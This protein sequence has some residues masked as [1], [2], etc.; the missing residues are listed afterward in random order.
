MAI[1]ASVHIKIRQGP[2]PSR[3]GAPSHSLPLEDRFPAAAAILGTDF[4]G[5]RPAL[6]V[7][8][9]DNVTVGQVVFRDR[10][11]TDVAFVAP[12][13]GRVT[14]IDYGPR[15]TLSALVVTRDTQS[16]DNR[17]DVRIDDKTDAAVRQTLLERGMWP[18][19]QTRPFGRIPAPDAVPEA[20]FVNAMQASPLAPNPEVVLEG[21]EAEFHYGV[22]L[23]TR[24]SSGQTY[25]CQAPGQAFCDPS[26]RISIA[27]FSGTLAAGLTGTH[28]HRLHSVSDG[29]QVWSIG[30]QDVIAIG[31]LFKTGRYSSDRVVSITGSR[32]ARP[33]LV[34]TCLGAS[35]HN[36]CSGE[37]A[38]AR[39]AGVVQILSG[40]AQAGRS[41]AFVGRYHQQITIAETVTRGRFWQWLLQPLAEQSALVPTGVLEQ[42]LA[43]DVLPVPLM[44]ALSVGDSEAAERLGCLELVEEDVVALSKFCTSGADYGVLLRDV[45]DEL[46]EDAA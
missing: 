41:A 28:I 5:L 35:I 8:K 30:Y 39:G 19:F 37:I 32:A 6:E 25:V 13:S 7:A 46:A 33:K 22:E 43:I 20:I 36:V 3:A 26:E 29:R 42:A 18:A 11:N 34:R 2:R 45:L 44:R 17:E 15:R 27:F 4:P 38:D 9:G 23:L 1:A 31:R 21:Q 24:L 40:D 12:L 14:S 10:K 16:T